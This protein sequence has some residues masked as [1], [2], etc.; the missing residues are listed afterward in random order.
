MI[1]HVVDRVARTTRVD[2]T[3]VATE[4]ERIV[5][6]CSSAG[7]EVMMTSEH[8]VTGTDR[9]AEVAG[10]I[11]AEVI[12]N[13]QGD[14]PLID[15]AGIDA[16]IACLEAALP[17]GIDVSTGYLRGATAEQ[18]VSLS[19]VH[20]VRALDGTV[21]QLSRLAV[22]AAFSATP[23]RN[24]HLGLYA[25]A[26]AALARF[27]SRSPGPV[28][29]AESIE[30]LR[31]LEHGERIA[32]TEVA[33]GSIAVDHPADIERVEAMLAGRQGASGPNR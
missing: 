14:E 11:D 25:F 17:R 23:E 10:R 28:E 22:P 7:V 4:D 5:D 3:I 26:P 21:L 32:C 1:L 29:Q 19:V 24:V 2:R 12:V 27:S 6:V 18:E 20:L 31:F 16:V 8:H 9:L 13:V 15:P 33:G 30:L